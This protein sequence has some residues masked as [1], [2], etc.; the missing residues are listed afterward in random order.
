METMEIYNNTSNGKDLAEKYRYPTINVDNI[1]AIGTDPYDIPDR[2]LPPVLDPY[3]ASE[4]SKSQIPSLSERIKN[5]VKTN[6]YDDMKHMSP[7]GYMASDQSYKG[8]FNLTGPEISLEDSRYRLSSGT[9]IPKYESYIPGVDNDTRLS[10]SQGRTEKWMRG[11]GKFVGKAALYG[12]GGVIQPFYGIYAGVSRGNFNAVFDND[13]TRWLDDQDKKMDYGLAHYY[14][15]EERDM[16]FLQSMTTAN[17]WSN[18]FYP[19]LLLPLEP[20][21]RQPYIPALD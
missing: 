17:F 13:F 20:C 10:R 3:S 1:K 12:L 7:L 5:T 14:N 18:D 15:R 11:L 19:V 21:Y 9:W 2:D 16:N 8:R 4:R 6:Y